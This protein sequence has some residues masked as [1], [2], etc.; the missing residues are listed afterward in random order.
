[1]THMQQA[2]VY[3]QCL[4]VNMPCQIPGTAQ[5]SRIFERVRCVFVC[6]GGKVT[7]DHSNVDGP[8]KDSR[9]PKETV[10]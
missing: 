9:T 1:M 7:L 8:Y 6:C 3:S 10:L 4:A 2:L 5:L